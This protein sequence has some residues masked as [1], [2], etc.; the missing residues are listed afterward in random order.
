ML[1][2]E[3]CFEKCRGYLSERHPKV[4]KRLLLMDEAARTKVYSLLAEYL[5]QS[6]PEVTDDDNF[7]LLGAFG[8]DDSALEQLIEQVIRLPLVAEL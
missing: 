5:Q 6:A 1:T 3:K 8:A 2:K 4:W 7:H